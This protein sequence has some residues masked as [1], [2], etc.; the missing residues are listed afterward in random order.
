MLGV[1][2]GH[3]ARVKVVV[4][5]VMQPIAVWSTA[6]NAGVANGGKDAKEIAEFAKRVALDS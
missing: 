3:A 5:S 1:C 4:A 6:S 2:A